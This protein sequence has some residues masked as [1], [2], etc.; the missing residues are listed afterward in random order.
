MVKKTRDQIAQEIRDHGKEIGFPFWK[1]QD[2]KK[3]TNNKK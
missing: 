2:K 3:K 1:K